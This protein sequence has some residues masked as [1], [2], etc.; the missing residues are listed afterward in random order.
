M[1]SRSYGV[2]PA[3]TPAQ[4]NRPAARAG[5]DRSRAGARRRSAA[6]LAGGASRAPSRRW[7]SWRGR[8][9]LGSVTVEVV[10]RGQ[11]RRR[12]RSIG[13]GRRSRM[14]VKS[15]PVTSATL[16]AARVASA[17]N[18]GVAVDVAG[19]LRR[20]SASAPGR[21]GSPCA[22]CGS[23]RRRSSATVPNPMVVEVVRATVLAL[24]GLA[25]CRCAP[26]PRIDA[27]TGCSGRPCPGRGRRSAGRR[28][29]SSSSTDAPPTSAPVAG[30]V[31][32]CSVSGSKSLNSRAQVE[33]VLGGDLIVELHVRLGRP[34]PAGSARTGC[35]CPWRWPA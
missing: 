3:S 14:P 27:Q 8:R 18:V 16:S 17:W 12:S 34:R 15:R 1:S 13:R 33:Q 31:Y 35:G 5:P 7:W 30:G 19:Q 21:S 32:T 4:R 29:L 11:E 24:A 23:S 2:D 25:R 10:V 9:A 6:G 20:P 22:G 28:A 26:R